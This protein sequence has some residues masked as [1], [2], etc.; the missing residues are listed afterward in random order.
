MEIE[1]KDNKG[2][3]SMYAYKYKEGVCIEISEFECDLSREDTI[4]LRDFLNEILD[5]QKKG[6]LK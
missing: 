1:L 4:R 2:S 6:T 3:S 5:K